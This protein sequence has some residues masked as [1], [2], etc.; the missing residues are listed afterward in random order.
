MIVGVSTARAQAL[1]AAN[2]PIPPTQN[3]RALIDTGASGTCI[4]PMVF[5]ALQLQPTGSIPM[6]T[7]STGQTP[8]D[9]DTYDV[10]IMIPNGKMGIR[11]DWSSR[12]W[13]LALVNY[14]WHKGFMP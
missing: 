7:P 12:T 13:R 3:I 2:Q 8:V 11:L 9:A 10:A 5:K 14:S 1:T 6:L 4:D